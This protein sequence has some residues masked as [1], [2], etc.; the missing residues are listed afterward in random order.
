MAQLQQENLKLASRT[1]TPADPP[2]PAVARTKPTTALGRPCTLFIIHC[3]FNAM[4]VAQC[5][6][7]A[8]FD[9]GRMQHSHHKLQP[10][11]FATLWGVH[12]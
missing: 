9:A 2:K 3:T 10:E 12:A 5:T 11:Q 4:H 8:A 1:P 7:E 6:L